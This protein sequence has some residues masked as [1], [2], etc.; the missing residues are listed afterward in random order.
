[1]SMKYK[2]RSWLVVDDDTDLEDLFNDDE[3]NK[4]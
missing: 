3:G 2:G 4:E 1:M